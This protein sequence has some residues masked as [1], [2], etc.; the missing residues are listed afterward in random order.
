MDQELKGKRAFISGASSGIG[1][2]MA[3]ELAREGVDVVVHGRDRPRTKAT[4]QAV[5]AQGGRSF[6]TIGDLTLDEDAARVA[7]EALEAFGGI[8]ILINNVGSVLRK[9]NPNWMNVRPSEWMDSF[10]LNVVSAVRMSQLFSPGMVERGW[11]RII[12]ISST[13]STQRRGRNM[14]YGAAKSGLDNFTFN[15]SKDLG[16]KGVTVNA[17][18]PGVVMTPAVE[19]WLKTIKRQEGWGD[20]EKAN[21][22]AYAFKY[23]QQSVPTLGTP[24][25][26]AMMVAML[27]SPLSGYANGELISI[28]GG[29][30][31]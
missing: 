12:N 7:A 20:D 1:A 24:R 3:L 9:D 4:A 13:S 29:S 25:V 10:N 17:V 30:A 2:V 19:T 16:P 28:H 8:D 14:D 26:I 15:L 22:A 5:A 6:A 21:E 27:C 18:A 23:K 31:I 11:G